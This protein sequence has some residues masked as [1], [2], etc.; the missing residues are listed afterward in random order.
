MAVAGALFIWGQKL[1]REVMWRYNTEKP[2]TIG[3]WMSME[4]KNQ[5]ATS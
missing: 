1:Q 5:Y 4:N 3:Y 2:Y